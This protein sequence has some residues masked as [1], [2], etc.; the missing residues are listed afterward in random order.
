MLTRRQ[1][2]V[3]LAATAASMAVTPIRSADRP[4]ARS[5]GFVVPDEAAPHE[6]TF[7]QWPVDLAAYDDRSLR[8]AMRDV[9]AEIANTVA[10]FEP[11]VMLMGADH[12]A[13]ARR[14]LSRNVEIWDVP[15][16]D[17]WCRDSGPIFTVNDK[18]ARAVTLLNF[19]GWGGRG[20]YGRD[21]KV[22]RRVAQRLGLPVFDNDVVG[23]G[24]G[25][26]TDG[27][28]TLLA[29]ESSWVN[30]N[31][32]KGSRAEIEDALLKAY[33]AQKMIWAPGLKGQDITDYHIDSLARFV[34]PGVIAIQLGPPEPGDV[35]SDADY[36]TYD[37]LKNATDA[38]GRTFEISILPRPPQWDWVSSHANYYVCN[39][40]V[41]AS[42][43]PDAATD[44]EVARI[45]SDLYPGR[46]VVFLDTDL[47][48]ESGG[49]IHCATQQM[50]AV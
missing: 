49:G 2:S 3:G 35:W 44:A 45:L 6:L 30:P 36:A 10:E 46:E 13:A 42:R 27:A 21:G 26:E 28:G 22:A 4:S 8:D 24:G 16:D 41:L 32:N 18:G 5:E 29:H 38:Q 25:L 43:S 11:V 19:N 12:I 20:T 23:E 15:T 17:L 9:I 37:I 40:G 48:G 7:M 34:R 47:L 39:G 1:A 50:P 14:G 31:R 33:G